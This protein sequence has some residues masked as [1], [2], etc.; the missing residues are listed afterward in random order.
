MVAD[1]VVRTSGVMNGINGG[2][3]SSETTS[4]TMK[5]S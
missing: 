5:S 1:A 2:V 4:K 3:M